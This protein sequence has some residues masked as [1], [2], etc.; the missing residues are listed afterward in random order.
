M[1]TILVLA[2]AAM[3]LHGGPVKFTPSARSVNT[4]DPFE[5]R[6]DVP[7]PKFANCFTDAAVR[8]EFQMEGGAAVPVEG[9]CDAQDGR[10]FRIRFLP[11]KAGLYSY[12]LRFTAADVEA[13]A[14]GKFKVKDKGAPGIVR[15]DAEHPWHF[16]Y[17][18]N[19]QHYFWNSTT[20]YALVGW[21][22]D[23]MR[24]SLDR[25]AK[26][27]VNRIR[28]A[29]YP[30][31]VESG[32]SWF[33]GV[34]PTG[35]FRFIVN[36]WLAARPDSLN[37]PGFD[38][39]RFNV[40]QW[41]KYERLL[42]HARKNG[43]QVSV[44][45]Y[46]DGRNAGTDPFGKA[47]M[48]NEDEQRYY[49]Y[50]VN[51][52]AAYSNVMWDVTNEWHL[53]RDEAW[54]EKMGS[55]IQTADPYHHLVSCHGRGEFPWRTSKWADFA[56]YQMWDESGGYKA[57]LEH[58]RKQ[59]AVGRPMPQ[60]NEEYGYEDHYP[61]GW[62]EN[63]KAPA[64]AADNRRRLA[65]EMTMAGCYQTTGERAGSTGGWI[66]GYGDDSM[67]M[68]KGYAHL[69]DFFEK[70]E[71]WKLAPRPADVAAGAALCLGDPGKEYVLYFPAGGFA[72]LK[73]PGGRYRARWFN[74]RTGEWP[75]EWSATIMFDQTW[76]TPP[77]PDKN[78]WALLLDRIGDQ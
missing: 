55:L 29:F 51:R 58:R 3:A 43:I 53:F 26:L 65:W 77:A 62:G 61:Q 63:R 68:L 28:A 47:K 20:A 49:R 1:R 23:T 5:V 71:Y 73:I 76:E 78:D 54:V 11:P 2:F 50:A 21:D 70:F 25:L 15:V 64:R 48:G 59:E 12:S 72:R 41:Q 35:K 46:V 27:K 8:G 10:V 17:S 39:T 74:P 24:K 31:R 40:A 67:T 36:P 7:S 4:Y 38:V 14:T 13:T 60:I 19:G 9:F 33:E 37:D 16:V 30:P 22:D 34:V 6:V 66:N 42:E 45:F 75:P 32:K 56:M 57:M 69:R 18:G 44:I 52:F